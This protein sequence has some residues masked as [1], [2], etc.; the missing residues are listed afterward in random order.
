MARTGR[1]EGENRHA[2]QFANLLTRKLNLSTL[3]LLNTNALC[4]RQF[5]DALSE[6]LVRRGSPLNCLHIDQRSD[7]SKEIPIAV[8]RLLMR[9]IS[10]STRLKSLFIGP[11]KIGAIHWREAEFVQA[12]MEAICLFKVEEL[13][14]T[15]EGGPQEGQEER[16]IEALRRNYT[17]QSVWCNCRTSAGDRN[18]FTESS[19]S[20]LD[21]YLYRNKKLAEWVANP[22]LVPRE[23]WPEA[24]KLALRAGKEALYQSLLAL[25]EQGV[26]LHRKGRKRKRPRYYKPS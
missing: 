5:S 25:S 14:L 21:F 16:L 2:Q 18:F 4:F 20:R 19:Q 6:V 9:A 12:L 7:F 10:N 17:I 15:F 3:R 13:M 24:M 11:I 22:K 26:G 8:F 23:L 1:E